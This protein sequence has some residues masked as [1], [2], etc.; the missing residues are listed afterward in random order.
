MDREDVA[1]AMESLRTLMRADGADF[2]LVTVQADGVVHLR[3][4]LEDASCAPCVMPRAHLES[5]ALT[6]MKRRLPD[7]RLVSVADPREESPAKETA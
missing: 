1:R 5:V 3:L 4:L 6:M 2:E 7:L